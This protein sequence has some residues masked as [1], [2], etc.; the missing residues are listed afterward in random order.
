MLISVLDQMSIRRK[1]CETMTLLY[2][3]ALKTNPSGDDKPQPSGN[4]TAGVQLRKEPA[5]LI[6]VKD[7]SRPGGGFYVADSEKERASFGLGLR[8]GDI[9]LASELSSNEAKASQSTAAQPFESPSLPQGAQIMRAQARA[10]SAQQPFMQTHTDDLGHIIG[11][12]GVLQNM[13][14][15]NPQL[16]SGELGQA[17]DFGYQVSPPLLFP[18]FVFTKGMRTDANKRTKQVTHAAGDTSSVLDP[19][20]LDSLPLS[21]FDWDSW[22]T[23][24]DKVLP[25]ASNSFET[26]Q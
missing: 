20:F 13:Q 26:M 17:M 9:V 5:R 16:G 6:F 23:Y 22:S 15:V 14:N 11:V 24:F 7:P 18:L 4:P 2:E 21:T 10:R 12:D 3:A 25:S 1:T 19:S 8:K